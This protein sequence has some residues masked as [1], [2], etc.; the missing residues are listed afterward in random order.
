MAK[1]STDM[2]HFYPIHILSQSFLVGVVWIEKLKRWL[3][4]V[5]SSF[6]TP[7]NIL[8]ETQKMYKWFSISLFSNTFGHFL[9]L[10]D[11]NMYMMVIYIGLVTPRTARNKIFGSHIRMLESSLL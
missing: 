5:T 9:N 10:V 7:P 6:G 3:F 4:N 2:A 11:I 1:E 8:D